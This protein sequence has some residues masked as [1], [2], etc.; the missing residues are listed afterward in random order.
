MFS[1]ETQ[2]TNAIF[3]VI[4]QMMRK[5]K[6]IKL[7]CQLSTPYSRPKTTATNKFT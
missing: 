6:P 2:G 7:L 3:Q 1:G 4:F 5:Q